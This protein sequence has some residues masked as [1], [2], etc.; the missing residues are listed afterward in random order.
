MSIYKKKPGRDNFHEFRIRF[1]VALLNGYQSR[2]RK[3]RYRNVP[4]FTGTMKIEG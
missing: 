4:Q 1:T 3:T 2:Y